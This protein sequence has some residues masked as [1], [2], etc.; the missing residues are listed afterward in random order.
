MDYKLTNYRHTYAFLLSSQIVSTPRDA[1]IDS[2]GYEYEVALSRD[3]RRFV[4]VVLSFVPL[5]PIVHLPTQ[6]ERHTK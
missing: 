6:T 2:S 1:S 3:F 5:L 4:I